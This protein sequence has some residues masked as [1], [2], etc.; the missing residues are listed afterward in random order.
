MQANVQ[1]RLLYVASLYDIWIFKR[2]NGLFILA[3][4]QIF[5]LFWRYFVPLKAAGKKTASSLLV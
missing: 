4:I 1:I 3:V 5:L 2:G